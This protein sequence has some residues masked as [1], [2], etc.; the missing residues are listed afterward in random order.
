M[1]PGG[2][3]R[4][5]GI[6]PLDRFGSVAFSISSMLANGQNL[7]QAGAHSITMLNAYNEA[8]AEPSS[9]GNDCAI[10]TVT[11]T[12]A[13]ATWDTGVPGERP[14]DSQPSAPTHL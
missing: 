9:V 8:L 6:L 5:T 11:R 10:F 4:A 7:S 2:A 3:D 14:E 13:E 12:S 1:D